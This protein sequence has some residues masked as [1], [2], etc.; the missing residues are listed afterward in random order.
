MEIDNDCNP[1]VKGE[2]KKARNSG[3]DV[4]SSLFEFIDNACDT[5]CSL[6]KIDI[7]E[8]IEHDIKKLN[9]IIISD[10]NDLGISENNLYKI[11]SWTFD[12]ER[13]NSNI[14]EY[15]TGFK[16]ASVNLGNSLNVITYD[17][18]N[19]KYLKAIADWDE[20]EENNR[21]NPKILEINQ[22]FYKEYHPFNKGT[23]FIIENLR[24]EFFQN[25]KESYYLVEKLFQEISY[26]YKYYLRENVDKAIIIKGIYR[27][28]EKKE[29]VL[30][31]N[32]KNDFLY[33]FDKNDKLIYESKI[34]VYRDYA[35]FYNFFIQK[36][37]NRNNHVSTELVEFIEKRKNGN[38]NLKCSEI[39]NRIIASMSLVG[40]IIFKSCNY[41]Q[42][43]VEQIESCGSVDI[44]HNS[45]IVGKEINYR[46]HRNDEETKYI[47]HE[48]ISNSK[49]LSALLGIQF[50]KKSSVVDNDLKYSLEYLQ[51][52][53]E[54]ELIR[55]YNVMSAE[56]IRMKNIELLNQKNNI[57]KYQN[58]IMIN[59]DI[60]T[61]NNEI[62]NDIIKTEINY[63]DKKNY[64][65]SKES[66]V[67]KNKRRNFSLETKLQI[68]KK[69]ECRDSDFDFLLKDDILPLDYD[70]KIDR[71]NN[72]E[73]NCQALSV[74]SH[75][76]KTRKPE[77]YEKILQNKEEYIINLLNCLTSSKIFLKMYRKNKIKILSLE[78][79]NISSG[80]FNIV[81]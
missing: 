42:Q 39:S 43:N 70:H 37:N 34:L 41:Y 6:I 35:N 47:K 26:N 15:G 36:K 32:N 57:E 19:N 58:E 7:K 51:T 24:H 16:S 1:T 54:R 29:K 2:I 63:N 49:K 33:F 14:G 59:N 3:Y 11:F 10:N 79:A 50:N 13:D 74:I 4:Q 52:F 53:H 8:K 9:K 81:N 17:V 67:I 60:K 66:D 77:T 31:F 30:S 40:E 46:N 75:A 80:I 76:I 65:E 71:S 55:L 44:I 72:S 61:N 38:S 56:E 73:D 22:L 68:I 27:E 64:Y 5:N 28:G 25:Q 48:I 45:R 69:Q 78:D 20:M 23:S 62:I 18:E 21:W 12:R